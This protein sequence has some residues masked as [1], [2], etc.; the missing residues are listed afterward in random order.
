MHVKYNFLLEELLPK[1][2]WVKLIIIIGIRWSQRLANGKGQHLNT[3]INNPN[4]II[5]ASSYIGRVL[6]TRVHCDNQTH[7]S[8]YTCNW[9]IYHHN[10]YFS[11][12]TFDSSWGSFIFIKTYLTFVVKSIQKIQKNYYYY[13]RLAT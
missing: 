9:Y 1:F 4:K 11:H 8:L 2:S 3:I 5:V 12:F 6:R 13:W 7:K 10:I